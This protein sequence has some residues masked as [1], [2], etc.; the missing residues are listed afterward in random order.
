MA[1]SPIIRLSM[2]GILEKQSLGGEMET[3]LT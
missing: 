2:N 1:G 3:K